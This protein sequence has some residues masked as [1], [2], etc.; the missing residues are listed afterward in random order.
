MLA[1]ALRL[2]GVGRSVWFDRMM[3]DCSV[4]AMEEGVANSEYFV[5]FLTGSRE[6]ATPAHVRFPARPRPS[7]QP[8]SGGG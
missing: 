7:T 1:T 4:A 8:P 3:P 6:A 2:R 5:L